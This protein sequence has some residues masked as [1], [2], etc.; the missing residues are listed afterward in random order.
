[1]TLFLSVEAVIGLHDSESPAAL[2]DRGKLEGAVQ[3][4]S[5]GFG[6]QLVHTSIWSQASALMHGVNQ[7]HAFEDGNKRT[8]WLATDTFLRLNGL[9]IAPMTTTIEMTDYMVEV[10][11]HIH[12]EQDTAFWLAHNH[13][14]L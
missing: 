2:I 4:P 11:L 8:A 14:Q 12:S 13:V 1:M 10:T 7:A 6:G 3:R 5:S 9:C